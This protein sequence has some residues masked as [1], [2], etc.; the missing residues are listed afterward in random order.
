MTGEGC[1]LN[2]LRPIRRGLPVIVGR[3]KLSPECESCL[4]HGFLRA[5][6][7]DE[8]TVKYVHDIPLKAKDEWKG[9]RQAVTVEG[10]MR[11]S[12]REVFSYSPPDKPS[13]VIMVEDFTFDCR[14]VE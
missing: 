5:R 4:V 7:E 2:V 13:E 1:Q 14:E 8:V 12:S 3:E 9:I 6:L 10:A 11:R